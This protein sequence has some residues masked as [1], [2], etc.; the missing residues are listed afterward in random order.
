[1]RFSLIYIKV[2][3][4]YKTEYTIMFMSLI[5]AKCVALNKGNAQTNLAF[6]TNALLY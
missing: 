2:F 4:V 3:W 1:M 5:S 6:G